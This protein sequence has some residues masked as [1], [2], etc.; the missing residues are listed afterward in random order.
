MDATLIHFFKA[1]VPGAPAAKDP[2]KLQAD[3]LKCGFLIHPDLLNTDLEDFVARQTA[4]PN[5]TFYKRWQDVQDKD[6][7]ALLLDQITH[8]ASTYGTG[9]TQEGNGWVPNDGAEAPYLSE[10]TLI[11]PMTGEELYNRCLALLQGGAA[12]KTTTV[13]ALCGAVTEYLGQHPGAPFDIDRIRNREALSI[14]CNALGRRPSAPVDLLRYIVYETTHQTLLIQSQQMLGFI[15]MAGNPFDFHKLT[16][17]ELEGLASIFYRFK[18]L[19]LAFRFRQ[20]YDFKRS[21]WILRSTPNRA[22][23]NQ[24][25]RLATKHHVP[26]QAGFWERLLAANVTEE[27][28]TARL[29]SVSNFKLVRLLQ[30]IRERLL[31]KEGDP[32]MY[33]IR[34]GNVWLKDAP[35]PGERTEYL[36]MLER[37][38]HTRLVKNLSAKACSVR[39]PSELTLTCPASEKTFVGNFPFG[40]CYRM[41]DHNFFG[42][43]W[44]GE[45]GT[46]DFDI[47]FV[48][49]TGRKTGWN[50]EYNTGETLYSGDMTSAEPEA[51]ELLYCREACPDGTIY[52]NRYYGAPGS[53]FRFFFGQQDIVELTKNYMVD[54]G[55]VLLSEELASDR[56]E[57][58]LAVVCRGRI[59]LCDFGVGEDRVSHGENAGQKEAVL[60]RKAQCFLPLR[61]I[62][63]EAGFMEVAQD[64][65]LDL[66]DLKKDSLLALFS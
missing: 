59:W 66:R 28:L 29:D 27:E 4:D 62:L 22:V 26:M 57:K 19:F 65:D 2:A 12:L 25:R 58:M 60:A 23:I 11:V 39:F 15:R 35:A 34:N 3:A 38:L 56:R 52:I 51:T 8:Y 31:L 48:D 61:E 45:W 24:L 1:A 7:F 14:L 50:E 40:S 49:W 17:A 41:T 20:E 37:V 36:K 43:Y 53:R 32:V 5:S 64:P 47:S 42:I 18:K 54:P 46:Q 10:Y 33:I 55:A 6:R 9:F 13:Q 30:A 63:L 16:Q 44:R 21:A